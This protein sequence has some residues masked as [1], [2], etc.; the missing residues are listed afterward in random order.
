MHQREMVICCE[1]PERAA[2]IATEAAK[3]EFF[4][5][6]IRG[7]EEIDTTMEQIVFNKDFAL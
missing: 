6:K 3:G 1:S 2:E 5:D 7:I 4:V